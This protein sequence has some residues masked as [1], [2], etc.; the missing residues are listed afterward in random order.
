MIASASNFD[1]LLPLE[2]LAAGDW[3]DI[4]DVSGEP[5][6]ICRLAELGLRAGCR[7]QVLQP[8]SPCLLRIGGGRLSLRPERG[9]QIL[10]RPAAGPE[11]RSA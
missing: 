2:L 3:A 7:V 11:S 10:V 5:A 4:V 9:L 6:W 1:T 8:G